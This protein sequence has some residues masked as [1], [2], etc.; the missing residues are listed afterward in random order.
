[1]DTLRKSKMNDI[2]VMYAQISSILCE[3]D[4]G[5]DIYR[6]KKLLPAGT[7]LYRGVTFSE[8][9]TVSEVIEKTRSKASFF[10][11]SMVEAKS[12]YLNNYNWRNSQSVDVISVL[13]RATL[14]TDIVLADMSVYL[15]DE[16]KTYL[17]KN[18]CTKKVEFVASYFEFQYKY[19]TNFADYYQSNVHKSQK[20]IKFDGVYDKSGIEILLQNPDVVL[21]HIKVLDAMKNYDI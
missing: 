21:D 18:P 9:L 1:M 7:E 16:I 20:N 11:K 6:G 12:Y 19:L 10:S 8:R 4:G 15:E 14:K 17:K 13:F 5:N 2:E 3:M